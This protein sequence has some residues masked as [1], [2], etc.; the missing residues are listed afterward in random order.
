M[1]ESQNNP[2]FNTPSE[3]MGFGMTP[4]Q[5]QM[6]NMGPPQQ[7]QQQQQ[8]MQMN[9]FDGLELGGSMG[10]GGNDDVGQTITT[11]WLSLMGSGPGYG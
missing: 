3:R 5:Q 2:Q 7:Q 8:R 11:D 9:A 4:N 6:Q 10:D 1:D